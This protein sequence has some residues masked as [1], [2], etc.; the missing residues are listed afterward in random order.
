[1]NDFTVTNH[2]SI[3]LLTPMNETASE[4]IE[5]NLPEDRQ[6]LGLAVAVEHRYIA[7]IVTGIRNDG[8]IVG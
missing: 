4:W 5:N 1:M 3:F 2:G 8:L 7:D 6:T